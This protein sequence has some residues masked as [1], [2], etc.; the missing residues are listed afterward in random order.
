MNARKDTQK[1]PVDRPQDIDPEG[2]DAEPGKKDWR[3]RIPYESIVANLPF[4]L[5][6]AFLALIYIANGHYAVKNIRA[7]NKL[8]TEVKTLQWSY[9]D[10]KSD[11]MHESKLSKV[12]EQVSA[13]GLKI[14]NTP[15][16]RI[17]PEQ[18]PGNK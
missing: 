15:P 16:V 2:E 7:I 3:P 6:L 4:V 14:P 5:F 13:Y 10:I 12:A 1:K 18:A 9:L 8:S 17:P 11:L